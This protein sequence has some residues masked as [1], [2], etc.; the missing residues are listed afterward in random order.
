MALVL[1]AEAHRVLVALLALQA[2]PGGK[3]APIGVFEQTR[4]E[5]LSVG[6]VIEVTLDSGMVGYQLTVRGVAVAQEVC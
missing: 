5:V 3:P 2:Y 1:S 6:L 4:S